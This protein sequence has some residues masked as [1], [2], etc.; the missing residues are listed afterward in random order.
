MAGSLA[1][2][3]AKG[4]LAGHEQAYIHLCNFISA[5]FKYYNTNE[6]KCLESIV[7]LCFC[8]IIAVCSY[9]KILITNRIV[10]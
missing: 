3:P 10:Q 5:H 2:G 4:P 6:Q 8:P 9:H 7:N 1:K